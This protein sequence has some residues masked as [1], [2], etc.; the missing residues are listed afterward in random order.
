MYS[1]MA[2]E[3]A[4]PPIEEPKKASP[5]DFLKIALGFQ[6]SHN[7]IVEMT[8]KILEE[9]RGPTHSEALKV[10]V[11]YQYIITHLPVFV[12]EFRRLHTKYSVD[13]LDISK[14]MPPK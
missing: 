13:T 2:K 9:R 3:I 5:P 1:N 14:L 12:D 6:Q 7:D 10:G 4:P 8:S 11:S